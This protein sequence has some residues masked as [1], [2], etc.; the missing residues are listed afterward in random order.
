MLDSQVVFVKQLGAL[1]LNSD[2]IFSYYC[3]EKGR[4]C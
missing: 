4:M 3:C 2:D 1:D